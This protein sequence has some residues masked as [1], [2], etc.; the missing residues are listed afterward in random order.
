LTIWTGP[1]LTP[2][3]TLLEESAAPFASVESSF[4]VDATGFGMVTYRYLYDAKYGREMKAARW[5]KA[6]AMAGTNAN[7]TTSMRVTESNFNDSPEL[8]ALVESSAKQFT[9][10]EVSA[11]KAYLSH[12]N[13]EVAQEP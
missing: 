13:L 4:A 6:H 5:L 12:K 2:L 11:H 8:P 3:L 10:A 9:L 1:I 7:V